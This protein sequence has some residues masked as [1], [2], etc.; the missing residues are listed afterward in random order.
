MGEGETVVGV[1]G[2]GSDDMVV[3][4]GDGGGEEGGEEGRGCGWERGGGTDEFDVD[5]DGDLKGKEGGSGWGRSEIG[6][7]GFFQ[8]R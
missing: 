3:I 8:G 5:G 6:G 2:K 7:E 4:G 1:G